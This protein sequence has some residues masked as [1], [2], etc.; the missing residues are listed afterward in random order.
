MER[1]D[2][3]SYRI[4][5]RA[6]T[7]AGARIAA[8]DAAKNFGHLVSRVREEGATY[9]VERGGKPVAR[10]SPVGVTGSTMAAL[11]TL[12]AARPQADAGYGRAVERAVRRHNRPRLHRNPWAR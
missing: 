3:A 9:I 5:G 1:K 8:T 10:I 11:K 12:V 7:V 6:R 4:R 2:A